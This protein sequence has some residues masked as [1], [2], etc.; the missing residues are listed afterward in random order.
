MTKYLKLSLLILTIKM[1]MMMM[2]RIL[3]VRKLKIKRSKRRETSHQKRTRP[4]RFPIINSGFIN[5]PNHFFI[6]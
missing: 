1:R 3:M 6:S 4:M 5:K 2:M